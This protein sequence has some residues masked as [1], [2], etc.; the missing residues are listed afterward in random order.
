MRKV[1]LN[2]GKEDVVTVHRIYED[3]DKDWIDVWFDEKKIQPGSSISFETAKGIRDSD[4]FI[5]IFSSKSVN[6]TGSVNAEIREAI[7]QTR[8]KLEGDTYIIPVRL[9]E[10]EVSFLKLEDLQSVD[11]FPEDKWN[12][13]INKILTVISNGNNKSI[14]GKD[15][16]PDKNSFDEEQASTGEDNYAEHILI[17][18]TSK[19]Q[20]YAQKTYDFLRGRKFKPILVK[21]IKNKGDRSINKILQDILYFVP[22]LSSDIEN[23]D[24][25]SSKILEK[26]IE[27]YQSRGHS[28]F[29]IPVEMEEL[30]IGKYKILQDIFPVKRRNKNNDDKFSDTMNSLMGA[31]T[32]HLLYW[33]FEGKNKDLLENA[34]ADTVNR[35]I[36][37]ITDYKISKEK[38]YDNDYLSAGL[39][40]FVKEQY[41]EALKRFLLASNHK[42]DIER[43]E[44]LSKIGACYIRIGELQKA[45]EVLEKAIEIDGNYPT[46]HYNK[47]ILLKKNGKYDEAIKSFRNAIESIKAIYQ[48]ENEVKS[49]RHKGFSNTYNN[50]ATTYKELYKATANA[51]HIDTAIEE[52]KK[53]VSD[54]ESGLID[55]NLS[56]FLTIHPQAKQKKYYEEALIHIEKAFDKDFDNIYFAFKDPELTILRE[57]APYNKIFWEKFHTYSKRDKESYENQLCN[58]AKNHDT[59][60]VVQIAKNLKKASELV[61]KSLSK[62]KMLGLSPK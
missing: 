61:Q 41:E 42:L 18:Y 56:C 45:K 48:G 1:F 53:A 7:K 3:L 47:G 59:E 40:S 54:D 13:G 27:K 39:N 4:Y 17:W 52:I 16:P 20:E 30:S 34:T 12:E 36:S 31:I 62:L 5:L 57:E 25:A 26:A 19:H 2:Y 60:D 58:T 29:I 37:I 22:L 10:C 23:A 8:D 38:L 49:I 46:C 6:T 55:Y 43:P 28:P 51:T 14:E 50:M 44:I 11:L 21:D 9:D 15:K 32:N 33:D 35:Y 24:K